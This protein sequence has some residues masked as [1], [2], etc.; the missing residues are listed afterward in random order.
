MVAVHHRAMGLGFVRPKTHAFPGW[1]LPPVTRRRGNSIEGIGDR[2][3]VAVGVVSSKTRWSSC[4][5][6]FLAVGGG[7]SWYGVRVRI[8]AWPYT[9]RR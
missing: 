6:R 2:G 3:V 5:P 1:R 8:T 7:K 9:S 4:D